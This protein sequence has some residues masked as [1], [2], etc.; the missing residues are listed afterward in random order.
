MAGIWDG[1]LV[2]VGKFHDLVKNTKKY[3]GELYE[4]FLDM[5][6]WKKFRT[7]HKLEWQKVRFEESARASVPTSPGIY[8]F[9]LEL[10]PS[11]LPL[12]GYIMYVGITGDEDSNSNLRVR[13]GRYLWELATEGGRAATFLMMDNW[14]PDLFFNFVPIT[15]AGVDIGAIERA[16]IK[17][18]M[19]PINKRDI[20]GELKYAKAAAF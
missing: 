1:L 20:E 14:H 2:L 8:T 15:K 5:K 6:S 3:K 13:F 17:A 11:K 10:S 12:H 4:F 9:T 19:P 7:K 18:I 16:F